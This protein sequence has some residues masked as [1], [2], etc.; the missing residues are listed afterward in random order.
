LDTL[1]LG[2]QSCEVIRR[3]HRF[4]RSGKLKT[5]ALQKEQKAGKAGAS[6][7]AIL[8]VQ[9]APYC[10]AFPFFIC[11]ICEICGLLKSQINR[12]LE[13]LF[14]RLEELRPGGA[15]HHAMVAGERHAAA[16][17]HFDLA[18]HDHRFLRH[19]AHG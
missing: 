2:W 17:A 9:A 6:W 8:H 18:L 12:I 7:P 11:A 4:L 15:V 16:E 3:L 14:E 1:R 5:N 10:L 19:R 13:N